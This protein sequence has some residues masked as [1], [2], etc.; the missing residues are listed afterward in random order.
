M[1][2]DVITKVEKSTSKLLKLAMDSNA[3]KQLPSVVIVIADV[4]GKNVGRLVT[5]QFEALLMEIHLY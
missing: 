1:R 2:K 3:R 5:S 4:H